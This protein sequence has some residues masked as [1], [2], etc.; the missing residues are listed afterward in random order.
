Q[1][2]LYKITPKNFY[3]I[4]S[5]RFHQVFRVENLTNVQDKGRLTFL[6]EKGDCFLVGVDRFIDNSRGCF[7]FS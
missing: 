4:S 7:C 5:E 2:E 3:A 6:W 1:R